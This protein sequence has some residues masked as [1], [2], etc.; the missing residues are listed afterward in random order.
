MYKGKTCCPG[1]G[2]SGEE[3]PRHSATD[4]CNECRNLIALGKAARQQIDLEAEYVHVHVFPWFIWDGQIRETQKMW[5]A[6]KEF[7]QS[8]SSL[9]R[10]G[11]E[12]VTLGNYHQDG[13]NIDITRTQFE[14]LKILYSQ[15]VDSVPKIYTQAKKEGANL[16]ISLNNGDITMQQLNERLK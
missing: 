4:I 8:L 12:V 7:C 15:I 5:S 9:T 2:K 14:S 6:F 13:V 3:K 1:C 10:R 11:N 16:L